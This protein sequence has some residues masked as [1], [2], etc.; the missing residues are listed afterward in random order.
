MMNLEDIVLAWS[1]VL[2]AGALIVRKP[3]RIP[4]ILMAYVVL[5]VVSFYISSTI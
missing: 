1:L 4:Y 5:E 2:L 3:K